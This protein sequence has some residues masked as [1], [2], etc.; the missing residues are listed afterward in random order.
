MKT[1]LLSNNDNGEIIAVVQSE[2]LDDGRF[3]K[4]TKQAVKEHFTLDSIESANFVDSEK[5]ASVYAE[6]TM[7]NEPMGY[8]IGVE[9]VVCY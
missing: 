2:G 1:F 7:D 9:E 6:G 8:I 4:K 5:K 3:L